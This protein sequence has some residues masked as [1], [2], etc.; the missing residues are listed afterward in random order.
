MVHEIDDLGLST[1][2]EL[3]FRWRGLIPDRNV[4]NLLSD[5]ELMYLQ[6]ILYD[7]ADYEAVSE[8]ERLKLQGIGVIVKDWKRPCNF[9]VILTAENIQNKFPHLLQKMLVISGSFSPAA[10]KSAEKAKVLLLTHGELV[11]IYKTTPDFQSYVR[12]YR[13]GKKLG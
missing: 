11:S 8:A 6:W 9:K 12:D 5:K 10:E 2:A 7:A 3:F 1:L 13:N 4:I